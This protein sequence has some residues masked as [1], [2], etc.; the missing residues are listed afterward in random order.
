MLL[1]RTAEKI[2]KMYN[3]ARMHAHSSD[4]ARKFKPA[5]V[6]KVKIVCVTADGKWFLNVLP[7]NSKLSILL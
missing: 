4:F 3:I 7:K 1:I 2:L 5:R 6:I